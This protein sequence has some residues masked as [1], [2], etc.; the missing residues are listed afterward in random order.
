MK[1]QELEQY[2]LLV[3]ERKALLKKLQQLDAEY[4]GI[5]ALKS[6]TLD[7]MPRAA[8]TASGVALTVER[9]EELKAEYGELFKKYCSYVKSL[10]RQLLKIERE[11]SLKLN[12]L[13]RTIVRLKYIEAMPFR[14]IAEETNYSERQVMR[15][16]ARAVLKL[17]KPTRL[18][19]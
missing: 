8:P 6:P 18:K 3:L 1:K 14:K 9:A 15:L 13:E 19:K 7:G 2:R 16:C 10:D 5:G 4:R 12:P 11:I 17:E